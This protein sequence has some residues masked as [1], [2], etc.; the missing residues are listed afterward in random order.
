MANALQAVVVQLQRRSNAVAAARG[1]VKFGQVFATVRRNDG[2]V[3][4]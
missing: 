4:L 2:A 3:A 1:S